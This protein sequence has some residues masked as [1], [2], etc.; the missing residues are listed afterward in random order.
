MCGWWCL[1]FIGVRVCVCL[2]V[3]SLR[4]GAFACID[5]RAAVPYTLCSRALSLT[6]THTYT[7]THLHT[8]TQ[9][10]YPAGA[11]LGPAAEE[12]DKSK[13]WLRIYQVAASNAG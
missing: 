1:V 8:H 9:V 12:K 3:F 10:E 5:V 6:H 11:F 7:H 4:E 13:Y 2:Y